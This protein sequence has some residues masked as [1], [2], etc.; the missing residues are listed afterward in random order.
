M[1]PQ[2]AGL[3]EQRSHSLVPLEAWW[4][5]LLETGTLTGADPGAPNRAVSNSYSRQIEIDAGYGT[6]QFRHVTQH[7]LYDQAKLV[8]PFLV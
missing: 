1:V 8:E 2:T 4:C 3:R 5:E 6:K 7:G